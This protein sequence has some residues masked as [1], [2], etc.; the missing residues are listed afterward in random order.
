MAKLTVLNMVQNI[1]NAMDSDNVNSISDTIESL[2]VATIL[3]ET[4][5]EFM[6]SRDWPFLQAEDSLEGLGNTSTPTKM[7]MPESINKV[8]W[9]KYNK[10][11]VEYL[12]PKLFRD[13]LDARE[14]G[15]NVDAN[16]YITDQDPAYWTS[17]D[18]VYVFFDGYDSATDDTLQTSKS[19][20]SAIIVPTF[21]LDDDFIPSIPEKVFPTLLAEAKATCFLNLKQQANGR[22]ELRAKRGRVR[23]QNESWRN[24][25]GEVKSNTK[26]NYGRK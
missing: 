20:I 25:N 2:Q 4:F 21:T 12:P 1:L 13:M 6:S 24:D 15:T 26:I 14:A 18:D 10:K 9:I 17:F 5:Y 22:E 16:G 19:K 11:N 3:Q 8:F 7:R 23:L